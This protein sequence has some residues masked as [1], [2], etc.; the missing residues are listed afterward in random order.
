[1]KRMP[2]KISIALL[3]CVS[4]LTLLIGAANAGSI[5][6]AAEAYGHAFVAHGGLGAIG[7]EKAVPP[8]EVKS[9]IA[10]VFLNH[11]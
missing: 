1:M 5:A 11:H 3:I 7:A 6:K 10:V 9:E 2:S 8:G 4:V